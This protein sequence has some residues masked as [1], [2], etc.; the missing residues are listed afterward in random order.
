MACFSLLPLPFTL[1]PLLSLLLF[2]PLIATLHYHFITPL[3]HYHYI[4]I[5]VLL[6][7]LPLLAT[8]AM[9]LQPLRRRFAYY[10]HYRWCHAFIAINIT[11]CWHI[12]C[13]HLLPLMPLLLIIIA[14]PWLL[15]II[16]VINIIELR[17]LL[18]LFLLLPFR[19]Y[20][21][22]Y[23]TFSFTLAILRHYVTAIAFHY[24]AFIDMPLSATLLLLSFYFITATL[25]HCCRH[26]R[27]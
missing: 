13:R 25:P 17:I 7:I 26:F 8:Y 11:F 4:V 20:Y 14:T 10:C 19:L 5:I 21:Y 9:V 23:V 18:I 27:H 24:Y 15:F 6:L 1:L 22:H 12:T 2:T 3:R 16:I